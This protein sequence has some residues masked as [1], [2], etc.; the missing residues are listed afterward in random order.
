MTNI[1]HQS[2]TTSMNNNKRLASAPPENVNQI[3][4]RRSR[5]DTNM[6]T[7]SHEHRPSS[8]NV[9]PSTDLLSDSVISP[10]S[11][12]KNRFFSLSRRFRFRTQSP[13]KSTTVHFRDEDIDLETKEPTTKNPRNLPKE[14]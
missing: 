4:E 11:S 3:C 14:S 12:S 10:M 9:H 1:V 8:S 13:E 2:T 6:N 7:T 5:L